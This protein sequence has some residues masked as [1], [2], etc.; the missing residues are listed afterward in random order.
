MKIFHRNFAK[1]TLPTFGKYKAVAVYNQTILVKF[2]I[3]QFPVTTLFVLSLI[4]DS[5]IVEYGFIVVLC[6]E[7]GVCKIAIDMPP[8]AQRRRE[9]RVPTEI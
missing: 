2:N 4:P 8:L 9:R 3:Q 6:R 1:P 5:E 7:A